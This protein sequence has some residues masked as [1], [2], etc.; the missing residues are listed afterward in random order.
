MYRPFEEMLVAR[1]ELM[2]E[3]TTLILLYH[4]F[5][6]TSLVPNQNFQIM[7]GWSF[8]VCMCANMGMHLYFLL[9]TSCF[10][11]KAKCRKSSKNKKD[12]QALERRKRELENSKPP[13]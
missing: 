11:C 13:A 1:L 6:F 3:Y 2:N 12:K 9:R 8:I 5:M 7:V 10:D 4:V